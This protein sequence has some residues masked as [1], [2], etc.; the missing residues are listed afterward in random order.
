MQPYFFRN[1]GILPLISITTL[2]VS[3][4]IGEDP[5]GRFGT[6][7]KY[8]IAGALR[9]NQEF[10]ITTGG[11]AYIFS[12]VPE[13]ARN[14]TFDVVWMED[15]ASG[16]KTR[17][18]F[19]TELGKHWEPWMYIRELYSNCK[20]EGGAMGWWSQEAEKPSPEETIIIIAGNIFTAVLNSIDQFILSKPPVKIL[21]EISLHPKSDPRHKP[22]IFLKNIL[23]G[24]FTK[25]FEFD[26]NLLDDI[27]LTEDRVVRNPAVVGEMLATNIMVHDDL[28]LAERWVTNKDSSHLAT[29]HRGYLNADSPVAKLVEKIYQ[30]APFRLNESW[31]QFSSWYFRPDHDATRIEL[32][33]E[34]KIKFSRALSFIK[35]FGFDTDVEW[36]FVDPKDNEAYGFA[37]NGKIYICRRAFDMGVSFLAQ[38]MIEE[39]IHAVKHESDYTREFQNLI[40]E[41]LVAVAEELYGGI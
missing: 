37:M 34:Q 9:L 24:E 18:G 15:I 5:I 6:G 4:K 16:E 25:D 28:L 7:L 8:T 13:I 26:V 11:K 41:K 39:Y 29:S 1:P 30:E 17:L 31:R 14:K 36:N 19:T 22:K 10:S 40:L 2:G 33:P 12:K 3:D 21:S 23:V 32:T 27:E 38:V 20:D 35:K